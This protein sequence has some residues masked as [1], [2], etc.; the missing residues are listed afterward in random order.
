MPPTEQ[1]RW[2]AEEVK[3]YERALRAYLVRRFP[4]LPDHDDLI[5]ETYARLLRARADGRLTYVKAFLF[6]AARNIAIDVFR[7]RQVLTFEPIYDQSELPVL[8]DGPG[9]VDSIERQQQLDLL[10]EAVARLPERCH[11]VMML[12]HLDGLAYKQ[13]AQRLGISPETV[14]IH[15][16][17]GVRACTT[18]LREHGAFEGVGLGTAAAM[19]AANGGA[20]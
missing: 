19:P 14:K 20:A 10:I 2:F 15:L 13:I 12:R 7:H 6:T 18:H 8:E 4:T 11:E 16:M 1:A 3:P 17:R 5:Q 9:V